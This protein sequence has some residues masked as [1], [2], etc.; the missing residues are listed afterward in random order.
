MKK[1]K[2]LL[3]IC[4]DEVRLRILKL[5]EKRNMC[6]CELA[7]V[8]G[9]TQPGV[10]RHLKKLKRGGLIASQQSGYWTEY[11]ITKTGSTHAD[12]M[13]S[14]L[15]SWLSNEQQVRMDQKKAREILCCDFR[16]TCGAKRMHK[17]AVR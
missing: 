1:I 16:H 4:A 15:S 11:F 13:R 14:S 3:A 17:R 6:V 5:L 2:A 9:K 8:L 7:Y 12:E 10:S